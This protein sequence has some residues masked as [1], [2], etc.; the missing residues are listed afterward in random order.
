MPYVSR[1]DYEK[2]LEKIRKVDISK[3]IRPLYR[4]KKYSISDKHLKQLIELGEEYE[5]FTLPDLIVKAIFHVPEEEII[6]YKPIVLAYKIERLL[7]AE[8]K[9]GWIVVP[10]TKEVPKWVFHLL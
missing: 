2:F 4:P 3:H 10:P 7:E 8:T 1:E 6:K 9:R 5:A